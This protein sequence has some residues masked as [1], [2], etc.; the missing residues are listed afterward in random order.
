MRTWNGNSDST[1]TRGR[2]NEGADA[3]KTAGFIS[4]EFLIPAQSDVHL[5]RQPSSAQSHT[6]PRFPP[7][8]GLNV[9]FYNK[10]VLN[11][12]VEPFWQQNVF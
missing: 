1:N 4:K 10:N 5:Q 2:F 6:R 11:E 12:A 8:F 3:E 9:P 7:H